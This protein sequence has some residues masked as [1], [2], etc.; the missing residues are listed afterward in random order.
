M[1]DVPFIAVFHSYHCN[2]L[3][4]HIVR[5]VQGTPVCCTISFY[6]VPVTEVMPA[7]ADPV[8]TLLVVPVE[9]SESL[10]PPLDHVVPGG[11]PAP[12]NSALC[13]SLSLLLHRSFHMQ[14]Y[15]K[16]IWLTLGGQSSL[17]SPVTHPPPFCP[18]TKNRVY[19]VSDHIF[20]GPLGR[21]RRTLSTSHT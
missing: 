5:P 1:V 16:T 12:V 15:S 11:L 2:T 19:L 13:C 18:R 7:F 3:D 14:V 10:Y 9:T 21:N 20:L 8:A 4:N 6:Y 17:S